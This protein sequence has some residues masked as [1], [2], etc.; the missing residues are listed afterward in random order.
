MF[1]R[2]GQACF[3]KFCLDIKSFALATFFSFYFR[4]KKRRQIPTDGDDPLFSSFGE[5]NQG[6]FKLGFILGKINP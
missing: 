6:N 4:R 5:T 2:C 1:R 3:V